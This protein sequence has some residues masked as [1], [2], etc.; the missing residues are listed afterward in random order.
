MP[1][2]LLYNQRHSQNLC[3]ECH[4]RLSIEVDMWTCLIIW[5]VVVFFFSAAQPVA[6]AVPA[7]KEVP[8]ATPEPKQKTEATPNPRLN[9]YII[10][11]YY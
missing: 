8:S 2:D 5:N 7:V 6:P 11:D 9:T 10:K 3:Y 1:K 4:P